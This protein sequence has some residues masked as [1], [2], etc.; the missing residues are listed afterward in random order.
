[1]HGRNDVS[2]VRGS[3]D[4][5]WK[6]GLG[7]LHEGRAREHRDK[8]ADIEDISRIMP[9]GEILGQAGGVSLGYPQHRWLLFLGDLTFIILANVLAIVLRFGFSIETFYHYPIAVL[10]TLFINPTTM[11]VIDLYNP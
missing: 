1:M 2:H 8:G 4:I 6:Q 10:E 7:D 5:D 9:R 11:Y 3:S